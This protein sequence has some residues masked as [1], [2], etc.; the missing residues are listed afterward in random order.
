MDL[1]L[2]FSSCVATG[3]LGRASLEWL[4]LGESLAQTLADATSENALSGMFIL[5]GITVGPL[6]GSRALVPVVFYH[7]PAWVT[8]V[9]GPCCIVGLCW[10]WDL[11]LAP[12]A[13]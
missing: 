8:V 4:L 2:R 5:G 12:Y 13:P 10:M 1:G 9:Y 7:R 3:G 6:L 11:T